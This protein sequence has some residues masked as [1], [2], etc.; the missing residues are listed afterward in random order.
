MYETIDKKRTITRIKTNKPD[1]TFKKAYLEFPEDQFL[2]LTELDEEEI[3]LSERFGERED[4]AI[5]NGKTKEDERERLVDMFIDGKLRILI[6][7]PRIIGFGLNLQNC[8]RLILYGISD[9]YERFYQVIRRCYR[10]GQLKNVQV[11]IPI[12][13]LESPIMNNINLKSDKWE[14]M[15]YDQESRYNKLLGE[16]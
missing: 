5:I 7:K 13:H 15:I 8:F 10:R 6:T 11:Y 3:I 2:I 12:T 1:Y 9:S 16:K 4:Y 14:K